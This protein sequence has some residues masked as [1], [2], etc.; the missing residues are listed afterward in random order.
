MYFDFEYGGTRL[1]FEAETKEELITSVDLWWE[2]RCSE[3]EDL[4]NGETVEDSGDIVE[5]DENGEEV[6]SEPYDLFYEH[7]HGD[8]AEHNTMHR[9]P[10]GS[11]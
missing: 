1:G 3:E 2:D 5:L 11:L 4:K 6:S 9:G 7:Y 10:G 8:W